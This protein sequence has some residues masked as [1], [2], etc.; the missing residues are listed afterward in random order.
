MFKR[1]QYYDSADIMPIGRYML[2][3][4]RDIKYFAIGDPTQPI[5][6]KR[7]KTALKRF[8]G[9][10]IKNGGQKQLQKDIHQL[11][12][13]E[14]NLY[15][16]SALTAV[17]AYCDALLACG[18]DEQTILEKLKPVQ[19]LLI[20]RGIT[21]DSIKNRARLEKISRNFQIKAAD[22]NSRVHTKTGETDKV[23]EAY[24]RSLVVI[25]KYSGIRINEQTDSVNKYVL[26]IDELNK[27]QTRSHGNRY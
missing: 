25:E 10:I 5:Q 4:C 16:H 8:N 9:S 3:T 15:L 26:M 17:V 11:Q 24:L 6:K 22:I 12:K 27:H 14:G 20:A 23:Y 7:L 21:P 18:A 19:P 2:A 13:D 1:V